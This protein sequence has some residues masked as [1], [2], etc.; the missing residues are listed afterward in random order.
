MEERDQFGDAGERLYLVRETK[1]TTNL[2]ELY[3]SERQKIQC[4]ERHFEGALGVDFKVVIS[5]DE[6]P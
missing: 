6:L 3:L 5:A 1:S 4:G 2:I